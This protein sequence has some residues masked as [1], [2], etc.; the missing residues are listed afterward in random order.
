MA[1]TEYLNK[2]LP[3]IDQIIDHPIIRELP[4]VGIFGPMLSGKNIVAKIIEEKFGFPNLS[5]SKLIKDSL[6]AQGINPPYERPTLWKES[7]RYLD[8]YG[9]G[10]TRLAF[11]YVIDEAVQKSLKGMTFDGLRERVD[12]IS[13]KKPPKKFV[14]WV[15]SNVKV[16]YERAQTRGREDDKVDFETFASRD[17]IENERMFL[18]KDLADAVLENNGSEAE[19]TQK[20][21]EI[22]QTQFQLSPH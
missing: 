15:E 18:A 19:L 5:Y 1:Y 6:A 9:D 3:P 8:T 10:L 22:L 2:Q 13:F 16:R 14:L 21:V 17:K 7:R 11:L 12:V 20:V 4:I